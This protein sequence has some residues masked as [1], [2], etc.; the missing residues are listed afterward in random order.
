MTAAMP[1]AAD[2]AFVFDADPLQ[3]RLP[4]DRLTPRSRAFSVASAP[5][6]LDCFYYIPE[7][8]DASAP[9]LVCVHG[10][11]RNALEHIFGFSRKA[12][13][14]G[15]ALVVPVFDKRA[16]SGYQTL[17]CKKDWNALNAFEALLEAAAGVIGAPTDAVNMFGFSGG[18]QFVHRFA[19]ARPQRVRAFA[20]AAPG[21]YTLPDAALKFPVGVGGPKSPVGDLDAFLSLR[22]LAI[23]GTEDSERDAVFRQTRKLDRLQGVNRIERARTWT[24]AVNAAA[25]ARGLAPPAALVELPGVAHSFAACMRSGMADRVFAY[26]YPPQKNRTHAINGDAS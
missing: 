2:A 13:E 3:N 7:R 4:A 25:S 22:M 12:D 11:S 18:G 5:P 21:W 10:V 6:A 1:G 14:T 15:A 19:M 16:F 23:V 20:F 26:L 8:L 24:R 9:P 17:G